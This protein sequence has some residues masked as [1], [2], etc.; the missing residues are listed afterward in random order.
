MERKIGLSCCRAAAN[1]SSPHAYQS[2]GLC[3][4][5]SRYGLVS[6]M[7]RFVNV[8]EEVGVM[9]HG[10]GA[11]V[12]TWSQALLHRVRRDSYTGPYRTRVQLT[13]GKEELIMFKNVDH[14]GASLHWKGLSKDA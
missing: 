5:C 3:A 8:A 10:R 2:T 6:L 13:S 9:A 4:C 7:S 11:A 14:S 1:A 12:V